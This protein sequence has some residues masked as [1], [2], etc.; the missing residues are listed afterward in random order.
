MNKKDFD[1]LDEVLW[2]YEDRGIQIDNIKP[3][4]VGTV[5]RRMFITWRI[6]DTICIDTYEFDGHWEKIN[7]AKLN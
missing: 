5:I 2:D 6:D 7:E 3:I 4:Y 1:E